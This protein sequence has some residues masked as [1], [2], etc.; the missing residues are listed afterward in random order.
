M[1]NTLY[2]FIQ[3]ETKSLKPFFNEKNIDVVKTQ[4][5]H[6]SPYLRMDLPNTIPLV[7]NEGKNQFLLKT[8]HLSVY[9][10]SFV[11]QYHYTAYFL[12][13]E[14]RKYQLHIYYGENDKAK[15]PEF[16]LYNEIERKYELLD[17]KGL[18]LEFISLANSNVAPILRELRKRLHATVAVLEKNYVQV[19]QD[20]SILSIDLKANHAEYSK[21]VDKLEHSLRKLT[22]LVS[23]ERYAKELNYIV[24]LKRILE[25]FKEQPKKTKAQPQKKGNT[26]NHVVIAIEQPTPKKKAT[27]K[28]LTIH[29][30]ID[31]IRALLNQYS[32]DLNE[33]DKIAL[34]V[35]CQQ[36]ILRVELIFEKSPSLSSALMELN[37]LDLE[38]NKRGQRLYLSLLEANQ[39]ELAKQLPSFNYLLNFQWVI[40]ALKARN[41]NLLDFILKNSSFYLDYEAFSLNKKQ[42]ISPVHYCFKQDNKSNS[43]ADC[44]AVLLEHGA[45]PHLKENNH[46]FTIAHQI[47]STKNHPLKEVLL[48]NIIDSRKLFYKKL[49]ADLHFYLN[50]NLLTQEQQEKI[51]IAIFDYRTQLNETHLTESFFKGKSNNELL[52]QNDNLIELGN[53]NYPFL[54][55]LKTNPL[56][57]RKINFLRMKAKELLALVPANNKKAL[58]DSILNYN[59]NLG[60]SPAT[61]K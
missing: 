25:Q 4:N 33:S 61:P 19:E 8:H 51:Q 22:P 42:Y 46:S 45:S 36:N 27:K 31:G 14:D 52:Q 16:S 15:K 5:I 32:D 6:Q 49:I 55:N 54:I 20:T 37:K 7:L 43:M 9:E 48:K 50:N 29:E 35:E 59:E 41:A 39:F 26:A 57:I 12:D 56:Y 24:K 40:N 10:N 53:E 21:Q 44:L 23:N 17:K 30:E 13:N 18:N 1:T 3:Q 38:I 60:N 28:S 2:N 58:K 34:L 11:G 47:L